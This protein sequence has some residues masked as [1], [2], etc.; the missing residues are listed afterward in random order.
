MPKSL[1]GRCIYMFVGCAACTTMI[2][3]A[4]FA[5]GYYQNL[6]EEPNS[7]KEEL[8]DEMDCEDAH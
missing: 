2:L 6:K 5:L 8:S 3:N 4:L 1:L 7:E